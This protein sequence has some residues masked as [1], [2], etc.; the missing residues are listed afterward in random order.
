M[1]LASQMEPDGGMPGSDAEERAGA[2]LA[3]LL[4]FVS[5]EDAETRLAFRSHVKRLVG[6]LKTVV[7]GPERRRLVDAVLAAVNAGRRL[8]GD[9]LNAAEGNGDRWAEV[10]RAV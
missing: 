6:F 10:G 2:S 5:Q 3:A 8:R 1:E 4:A 7:L 9:W